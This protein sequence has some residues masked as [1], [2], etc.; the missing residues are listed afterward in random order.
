MKA[1]CVQSKNVALA[2]KIR[3]NREHTSMEH[4]IDVKTEHLAIFLIYKIHIS[5]SAPYVHKI[6]T[7]NKQ[8]LQSTHQ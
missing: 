8:N 7:Y 1:Q 3:T 2:V 6:T 5:P 4:C